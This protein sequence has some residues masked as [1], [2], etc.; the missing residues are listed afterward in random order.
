MICLATRRYPPAPEFSA[1]FRETITPGPRNPSMVLPD[2]S[3][4]IS[5]RP[6]SVAVLLRS[7]QREE[8]RFPNAESGEHHQ[9]PVDSHSHATGRRHSVLHGAQEIFVDLH[10]FGVAGGGEQRLR[11]QPFALH[12]GIDEFG[13]GGGQLDAV[14]IE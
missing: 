11:D 9:E 4:S 14:D 2:S 8:D 1:T 12:H 5:I 7:Y 10:R 6:R 3:P 13:I